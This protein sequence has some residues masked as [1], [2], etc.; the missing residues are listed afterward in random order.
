LLQRDDLAFLTWFSGGLRV[1]DIAD[2]RQP[3]EVGAFVPPD[4]IV[5]RGVLP[6]GRLV[7]QTEDVVVDARGF[8]YVTDKNL[9]LYVLR[10]TG[11]A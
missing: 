6:L 10:F 9:G 3:R 8:I 5:R 7:A 2:P 4:P 11:E 1:V